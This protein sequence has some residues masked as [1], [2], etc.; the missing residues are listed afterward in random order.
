MLDPASQAWLRAISDGNIT[1][2]DRLSLLLDTAD[3][4]DR[5]RV[6]S[7]EMAALAYAT[8]GVPVFPLEAN[9]KKPLTQHGFKDATTDKSLIAAWWRMFPAANIGIPTG[10]RFDVWDIDGP[11][12][13]RSMF[14]GD[15]APYDH[16]ADAIIGHARTSRDGGH[17]L[18]V[19]PTGRGN[20]AAIMPGVDYRGLGGYVVAPPSIGANGHRYLFTRQ[21]NLA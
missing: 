15:P 10:L 4:L 17:H 13:V 5:Q 19:K 12:G 9:G 11:D 3:V 14:H 2:A 8:N 6:E 18:Y 20:G 16:L 7:L 21:L 1:E